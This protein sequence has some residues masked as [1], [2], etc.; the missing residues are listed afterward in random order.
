MV[1]LAI[2]LRDIIY[3]MCNIRYISQYINIYLLLPHKYQFI[4]IIFTFIVSVC[5]SNT[6]SSRF[7]RYIVYLK[8]HQLF[9]LIS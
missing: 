1:I 3:Y 4:I 9:M 5:L 2:T 6:K 7:E 8:F